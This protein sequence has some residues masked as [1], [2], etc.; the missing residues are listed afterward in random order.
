MA[1]L[2]A[3]VAILALLAC[4]YLSVESPSPN[5]AALVI[6]GVLCAFAANTSVVLPNDSAMSAS[7]MLAV[8]SIVVFH[9][10][11]RFL[12]PLLVGIAGGMYFPHIRERQWRKVFFNAGSLGLAAL[13]AAGVYSI[14]PDNVL[15][16]IPGQLAVAIPTAL[17]YSLVN[18][19]LLTLAL[20]LHENR[21]INEVAKELWLGDLQIYPFALMGVL[22]GRL[23]VDVGAWII[24]LFVA[25]I[26]IA[27]QAFASYLALREA[28]EATLST[29]IRVLEAKDKYTAGHVE[30]VARF[31]HLVGLELG[32]RS[33][34]LERLR[35]SSLMHDIGKLIVPNQILNKPGL[36]TEAEFARM[37]DHER[38]SIELLRQIDFLAPV[39]LSLEAEGQKNE[40][41]KLAPIETRI[42]A[43]ADAFDAMTS[44]RAY[45]RALP[46]EVAFA[47][48]RDKAGSQF[49]PTCVDALISVL[50]R[51]GERYGA[52]HETDVASFAI[53]PPV[54]GTGS[55]GLGDLE[56]ED[57]RVRP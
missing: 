7:F 56:A 36:L 15:R 27:R 2:C 18:F 10:D 6:L 49:E 39:V 37:R 41:L 32:L 44:T 17:T 43:V 29:L 25:P 13:A 20:A 55:A 19:V 8:S 16:S 21:P 51:R 35:Y 52:G 22:L 26:L 45:R 38:V 28:Q 3:G 42:V 34:T 5:V 50:E 33:T 40:A 57:R 12:G 4:A 30:R 23:Y 47:E 54:V 14:F 46:Q 24:P 48:L 31:A 9:E 53:P 11:A 1:A